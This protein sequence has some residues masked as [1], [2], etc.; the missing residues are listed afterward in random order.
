[1]A[2][3]KEGEGS[4]AN[5]LLPRYHADDAHH[6]MA[7]AKSSQGGRW[8]GAEEAER[9]R[10][11]GVF[12]QPRAIPFYLFLSCRASRQRQIYLS[13]ARQ[14]GRQRLERGH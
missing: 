2:M 9:G 3:W 8:E 14:A 5:H 7:C 6:A 12:C 4:R 11:E 10:G 1:M 13:Q